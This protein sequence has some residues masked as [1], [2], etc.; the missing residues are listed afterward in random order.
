MHSATV[1]AYRLQSPSRCVST[2]VKLTSSATPACRCRVRQAQPAWARRVCRSSEPRIPNLSDVSSML[3]PIGPEPAWIYWLRR[4]MIVGVGLIVVVA[5]AAVIMKSSGA[6]AVSADPPPAAPTIPTAPPVA[7]SWTSPTPSRLPSSTTSSPSSAGSMS[8][9]PSGPGASATRTS[10]SESTP[11]A[12]KSAH[13]TC[14]DSELR[15]TL[16][17][18]RTLKLKEPAT[19]ALSV[20]NGGEEACAVTVDSKNFQLRIYSGSD[21]IWS[22]RDCPSLITPI[23]TQLDSQQAVEWK[24]T[25]NGLRSASGC[26][27]DS[28]SLEAGNYVA[29]AEFS[30]AEPVKLRMILS[31]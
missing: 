27:Q 6:S 2:S 31:D 10:T 23:S 5:A 25:W 22:T 29:T 24:I 28:E 4:T 9:T 18:K 11:T 20:I 8:P 15:T 16:T 19:F 7:T 12:T 3:R 14:E 26:E 21:R 13:S 17:G 1:S 30:D